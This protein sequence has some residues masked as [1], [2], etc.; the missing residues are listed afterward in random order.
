MNEQLVL[1]FVCLSV[2]NVIMQTAN[3]IITVKCNKYVAALSNA[4][5]YGLYTI[6]LIYTQS[7]L[8]IFFKAGIV[9]A[10]NLVGVFIV[11]FIEERN[12]KEKMW[13]IEMT[14]PTHFTEE[15][16]KQL[17]AVPHHYFTIT[18]KHTIFTFYCATHEQTEKVKA[19]V[20][21]YNAKY[22]VSESKT[23]LF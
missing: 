5:A 16:D 12:Q 21:D 8:P 6:V 11:K 14:I 9:A 20:K 1:L 17:A 3:H 10:A 2:V 15:L 18:P 4:I 7:E 22:F 19:S 23:D 13:K